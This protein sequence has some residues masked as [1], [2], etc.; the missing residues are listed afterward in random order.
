MRLVEVDVLLHA[1]VSV[2]LLPSVH[3][4]IP[5]LSSNSIIHP[6]AQIGQSVTIG[7]F[8]HIHDGVVIGDRCVIRDYVELRPGTVVGT[9]CVIDSR[10]SC[11]GNAVIGNHVTLRYDTIIAR[12]CK[13]GDHTYL[14]PRVMTNNLDS[15]GV[16]IGGA[17]IGERCF[18]G[19]NAVIHHGI[20]IGDRVT[21][22]ALSFVNKDCESE[23][24]YAGIPA[25]I[26][27]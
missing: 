10:V 21:I 23:R 11:S 26:L 8:C 1:F 9:D 16:S 20:V 4:S 18:I 2:N 3:Q 22:G 15:G 24:V 14:S 6:G 19:T 13:I 17:H 27:K 7:N 12:G 25:K 5:T